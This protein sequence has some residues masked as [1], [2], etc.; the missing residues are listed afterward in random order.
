MPVQS[1]K[2]FQLQYIVPQFE[3]FQIWV[4]QWQPKRKNLGKRKLERTN[5]SIYSKTSNLQ[6]TDIK[7]HGPHHHDEEKSFSKQEVS[8]NS[9]NFSR[10]SIIFEFTSNAV[11]QVKE[12]GAI[13]FDTI[14]D[15]NFSG[16]I[17]VY[18]GPTSF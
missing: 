4:T 9:K 2:H 10:I 12:M 18:E 7:I 13:S 6:G 1:R 11:I 3:C 16:K 14:R 8:V 5:K 15:V 17:Q